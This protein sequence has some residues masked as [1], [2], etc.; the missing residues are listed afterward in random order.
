MLREA[1]LRNSSTYPARWVPAAVES[2]WRPRAGLIITHDVL[3]G[4]F[5]LNGGEPEQ[6]GRPGS[7]GGVI[8]FSPSNLTLMGLEMGPHP[9]AELDRGG[10]TATRATTPAASTRS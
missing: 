2:S 1:I 8:Y 7:P 5:T 9:V 10:R 6:H 3:G 4:G